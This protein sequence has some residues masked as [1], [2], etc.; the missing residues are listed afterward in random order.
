MGVSRRNLHS[1]ARNIAHK[2]AV[3]ADYIAQLA[4]VNGIKVVYADILNLKFEPELFN[5]DRNLNLLNFCKENLLQNMEAYAPFYL[6][7]ANL[8][9]TFVSYESNSKKH[10]QIMSKNCY[11]V[12]IIDNENRIWKGKYIDGILL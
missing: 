8:T 12:E 4:F 3:S 2:F 6:C 5:I 9:I 1:I 10:Y 11:E 7:S